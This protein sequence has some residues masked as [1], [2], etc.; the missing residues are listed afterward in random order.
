MSCWGRRYCE[1]CWNSKYGREISTPH[2]CQKP[3]KIPGKGPSWIIA[4]VWCYNFCSHFWIQGAGTFPGHDSLFV[5][6]S[7]RLCPC[8]MK[9]FVHLCLNLCGIILHTAE[10]PRYC[11]DWLNSNDLKKNGRI[12]TDLYTVPSQLKRKSSAGREVKIGAMHAWY[13]SG[14]I[15][16]SISKEAI[17]TYTFLLTLLTL[18]RENFISP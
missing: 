1:Y 16:S 4:H 12:L 7:L 5:S 9:C 17:S 3:Q 11:W 2:L 15:L 10:R 14:F 8:T 13:Q 18:C 6:S